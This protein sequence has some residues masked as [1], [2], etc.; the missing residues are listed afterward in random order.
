MRKYILKHKLW[1]IITVFFRSVGALM[2][3]FV[4]ILLQKIIDSAT[5]YDM[6]GFIKVVLFG[7]IFFCVMGINDY[8]NK[9]TQFIYIKKTLTNLKE[10]VFRGI[11]RK[12]YKSFNSENTAEYISR[13]TNDINMVETKFIIPYLE[14]IGDVLIFVA[15]IIVMLCINIWI[16]LF[17]FSTGILLFSVP[18]I[19]GKRIE[20][21]Q[22]AVSGELSNFTTKIKDIFLGYE[23]I[24]S[25]NIEENMTCEFLNSNNK[26][27]NLKFKAN[28]L[29]GTSEA[30]SLFIGIMTQV[31]AIALG[32][33]F[34]IKGSMTVGTLFAVVN[35]ANGVCW[36]IMWIVNKTTMIRGMKEVNNKLITIIEDSK[37]CEGTKVL[38][39]FDSNI[40][41]KDV[42]FSYGN[43]RNVLDNLSI[44]FKKNKKYAIVGRSGSGKSTLLKLLLGYYDDFKG[45]ILFDGNE[46]NTLDK[47]SINNQI[48]VIHQNVYMFDKTLK[49]NIVLGKNFNNKELD[50]AINVSGVKE[51]LDILPRGIDSYIGENGNNLSGGQRQRVAIARSLI[52][53]TPILLLDEGTS[54]LDSKTAFEIE[55]TLLNIKDL[56]VITVTHK[57]IEGILNRYDE[58]VVMDNGKI[59]EC[60][61][62][63]D[64]INKRGEF[65]NLYSIEGEKDTIL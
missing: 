62:F 59:I 5:N 64:L 39:G 46:Y 52:Q 22:S 16:T 65:Y 43:D 12:D 23:V 14:M 1:L 35:L 61:S 26:V 47:N 50:E 30:L 44:S 57:L 32:G 36:P 45:E 20:K 3:V 9:T 17:V 13:L 48:S 55:D 63:D 29:Q 49:E 33:Y 51:F 40:N 54:A 41:I 37:K 31:C 10:D 38:E 2:Q 27:E 58:I 24:K 19:F 6:N 25:Y 8:L 60:G 18:A 28:H 53:N 56:T 11:L 15:T 4:S 7:V 42:T 34:L 21:R